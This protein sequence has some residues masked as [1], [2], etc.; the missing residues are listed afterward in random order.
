MQISTSKPN[1]FSLIVSGQLRDSGGCQAQFCVDLTLFPLSSPFFSLSLTAS[2]LNLTMLT[3]PARTR[4]NLGF[5]DVLDNGCEGSSILM[6][7]RAEH[8]SYCPRV[9]GFGLLY[10]ILVLD[11]FYRILK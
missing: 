7:T 1:V 4:C 9:Q 6:P 8:S 3:L 5:V 10:V 2:P 11:F